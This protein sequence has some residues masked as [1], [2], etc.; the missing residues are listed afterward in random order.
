MHSP[1]P[2]SPRLVL[3]IATV[4]RITELDRLLT[5]LEQQQI[6]TDFHI[7]LADQ[8]APGTLDAMLQKHTD[9]QMTRI[10]LPSRG[11]S[12]AR[13][14]LLSLVEDGDILIFP[15]DDCWY[16]P[17][18]LAQVVEAFRRHL[19]AGAVLGYWTPSPQ[20]PQPDNTEQVLSAPALF[21]QG[22]LACNSSGPKS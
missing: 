13:N 16:A 6:C 5:S 18:T 19:K 10:L 2:D 8:N 14:A 17:D 7:Y 21:S 9:L 20:F 1:L 15:D 11:V 4:G 22:G 3:C 12:I